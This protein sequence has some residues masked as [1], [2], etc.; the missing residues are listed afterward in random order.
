MT[1]I[2]IRE[3]AKDDHPF[4][5]HSWL[6]SYLE[7][8]PDRRYI[9]ADT[10]FRHQHPIVT[11]ILS[12]ASVLVATPTEQ[13]TEHVILAYLVYEP[14][15]VWYAYTKGP[16]QRHGLQRRLIEESG[17]RQGFTFNALTSNG[18]A[19]VKRHLE[20]VY[21]PYMVIT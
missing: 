2:R 14:E 5:Y 9:R 8:R 16:F 21:N 19:S 12:T 17:L 10:Y 11:K 3:G 1:D 20:A 7:D 4:I 13:G 6:K 18:I 15:I